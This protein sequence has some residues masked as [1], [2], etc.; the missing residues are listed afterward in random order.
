MEKL[1]AGSFWRGSIQTSFPPTSRLGRDLQDTQSLGRSW[2]VSQYNWWGKRVGKWLIA[3]ISKQTCQPA[4]NPYEQ[5]Y[6]RVGHHPLGR[7]DAALLTP[8]GMIAL[9]GGKHS[10]ISTQHPRLSSTCQLRWHLRLRTLYR[11]D[12]G[13][14]HLSACPWDSG[15]RTRTS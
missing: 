12:R 13:S 8:Q 10:L 11:A 14:P 1:C 4:S 7:D 2:N 6:I 5:L 15:R 3:R 9:A